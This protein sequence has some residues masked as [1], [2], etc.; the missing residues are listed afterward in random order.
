M[1]EANRKGRNMRKKCDKDVVCHYKAGTE[2]DYPYGC[3]K[4]DRGRR[5]R[6]GITKNGMSIG[7]EHLD[8]KKNPAL[9][10]YVDE[11]A[12]PYRVA[13]FKSTEDAEW[14]VEMAAELLGVR[15]RNSKS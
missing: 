2:C 10:V 8:G 15:V 9:T 6:Y 12:Q 13:T 3:I 14:F 5:M 4:A 7:V 1:S 11:T